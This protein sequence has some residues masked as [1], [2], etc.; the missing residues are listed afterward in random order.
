MSIYIH[1]CLNICNIL[2]PMKVVKTET[3]NV[4][5][6]SYLDHFVFL[7]SPYIYIYIYIYIYMEKVEKQN[8]PNIYIYIYICTRAI[9]GEEEK[10]WVTNKAF[11]RWC[12]WCS[13]LFQGQSI[14]TTR[15]EWLWTITDFVGFLS[16]SG[17][18]WWN[19]SL[20][21]NCFFYSQLSSQ[22]TL[23]KWCKIWINRQDN[24]NTLNV[25]NELQPENWDN[26]LHSS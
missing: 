1:L 13:A 26:I 24:V 3:F 8:D 19:C 9:K 4:N 25:K 21:H 12:L 11:I 7:L 16:H 5:L 14:I 15:T 18:A 10:S 22:F 23:M 20:S 2:V 17:N 6:S